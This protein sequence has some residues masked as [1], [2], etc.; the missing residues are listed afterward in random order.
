MQAWEQH[1]ANQ[2]K[3]RGTAGEKRDTWTAQLDEG[4]AGYTQTPEGAD[5]LKRLGS[6]R[7]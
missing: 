1:T 3:V 2:D 5:H 6:P 7:G 4:R